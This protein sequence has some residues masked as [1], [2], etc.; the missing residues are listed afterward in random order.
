M[1]EARSWCGRT[2]IHKTLYGFQKLFRPDA[3][4]QMEY[5]LY[6]HGPYS[7]ALDEAL[8]E[9]EFY[10]G[11]EREESAPYGPRYA[12]TS[13]AEALRERFGSSVEKWLPQVRFVAREI[14]T[15]NVRELEALSTVMYVASDD[16]EALRNASADQQMVRV[17]EL[18]PHLTEAEV[19]Q[20]YQEFVRLTDEANRLAS[21]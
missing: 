6:K 13:D 2:H 12:V 15:K 16:S 18:K 10:G 11:L 14:G 9:M 1:R 4:L 8:E 5:I 20:A 7:F 17:R 19:R 3:N 21:C